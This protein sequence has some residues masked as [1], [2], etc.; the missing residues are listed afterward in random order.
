M[1]IKANNYIKNKLNVI[2]YTLNED[3]LHTEDRNAKYTYK[4]TVILKVADT[5]NYVFLY[6][7]ENTA[8]ILPKNQLDKSTYNG[9]IKFLNDNEVEIKKY[10]YC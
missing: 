4:P 10:S 9:I 7:S 5:K 2:K 3:S 1:P 8:W 6:I